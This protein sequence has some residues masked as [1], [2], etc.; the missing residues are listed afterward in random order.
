MGIKISNSQQH[1]QS[2]QELDSPHNDT[3]AK[4][5]LEDPPHTT[6]ENQATP[7]FSQ[8]Q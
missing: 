5:K 7:V 6:A 4:V 3:L 8:R 1:S 2:K